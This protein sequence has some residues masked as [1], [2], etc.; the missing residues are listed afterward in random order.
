MNIKDRATI[1][2]QVYDNIQFYPSSF[3]NKGQ[4]FS[5]FKL[6]WNKKHN[7]LGLK[8]LQKLF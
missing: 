3:E 7:R 6:L 4:I 1:F 2:L 5:S 8:K